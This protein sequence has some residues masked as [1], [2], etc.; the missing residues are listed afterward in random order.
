[1]FLTARIVKN[2]KEERRCR[3]PLKSGQ[4]FLHKPYEL[5]KLAKKIYKK[6]DDDQEHF[7]VVFLDNNN[8]VTGYKVLFSGTMD[9][10]LVDIKILFRNALLFGA[11][12]ILI[13]HNHPSN[14]LEPSEKDLL[15][16]KKIKMASD[17][18]DI[19]L[20]DHLIIGDK[21][22]HDYYSFANEKLI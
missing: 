12:A 13:I 21:Y 8:Q 9:S 2:E 15:I 19:E 11:K 10:A 4:C 5:F 3:N 6:L 7:T 17:I 18:L 22:C 14:N 20:F 16:T 1:M